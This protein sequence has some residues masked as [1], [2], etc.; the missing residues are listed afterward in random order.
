MS[1]PSPKNLINHLDIE[2]N[3]D[4]LAPCQC[5]KP[6]EQR[7]WMPTHPQKRDLIETARHSKRRFGVEILHARH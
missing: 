2:T 5:E 1:P 3:I 6:V 7:F 4:R